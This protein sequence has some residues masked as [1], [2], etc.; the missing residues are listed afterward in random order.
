[1]NGRPIVIVTASATYHIVGGRC[2]SVVS[3]MGALLEDHVALGMDVV[4]AFRLDGRGQTLATNWEPRVGDCV[5]F[6]GHGRS[7]V[8]API[9]EVRTPP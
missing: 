1:M 4:S 5:C 3:H 2:A 9:A 8:T 7:F 6:F